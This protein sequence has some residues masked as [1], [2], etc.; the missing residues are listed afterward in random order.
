MTAEARSTGV[1]RCFQYAE[2]VLSGRIR[3]GEK[4]QMACQRFLDDLDRSENDPDYPWIF[5]EHKAGRPVEFM[6][7]FLVP[8]KGDYDRMEL[9]GW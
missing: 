5:D 6:E 8:T 1:A 4:V 2:D 7:R 9:M 3:M